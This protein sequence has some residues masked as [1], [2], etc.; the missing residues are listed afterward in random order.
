MRNAPVFLA[1]GLLLIMGCGNGDVAPGPEKVRKPV[2]L[3]ISASKD[4]VDRA[5]EYLFKNRNK[6][7]SYGERPCVGITGLCVRAMA[8]SHR[9]YRETD[10]PQI[11]AAVEYILANVQKDG[12]IYN[13]DQGL[14]NYR[15]CIAITALTAV[16][17]PEYKSIIE[18]ARDFVV[19]M[20]CNENNGYDKT[21]HPSAY[22]GIGYGGDQRPD[23]ANTSY[24]VEALKKAGLPEDSPIW[25][26]VRKFISRCQHNT[27]GEGNDQ[28]WATDEIGLGGGF[29]YMPGNSK[30]GTVKLADGREVPKSYGSAT[31]MGILSLIYADVNKDDPRVRAA[32]QWIRENYNVQKNPGTGQQGLYYYYVVMAKCLYTWGDRYVVTPDGVKHDW[33]GELSARLIELQRKDGSWTNAVDRWWEGDPALV[34]AYS[35]DALNYCIKQQSVNLSSS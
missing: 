22:G 3:G 20:Q 32:Y 15:T 35:I 5:V 8:E 28:A 26:R 7:G 30:A 25:K 21:K 17:N 6:D 1:A 11:S 33:A 14:E 19:G 12:G 31:Y 29:V 23:I 16:E 18:K 10:G 24:A 2:R 34:T 4:A 13:S 27:E 9:K